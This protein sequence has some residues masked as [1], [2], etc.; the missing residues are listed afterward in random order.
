MLAANTFVDIATL[1]FSCTQAQLERAELKVSSYHVHK[2]LIMI[3]I[4][5]T[6]FALADSASIVTEYVKLVI[7]DSI[8]GFTEIAV[9]ANVFEDTSGNV[10]AE[11]L[12]Y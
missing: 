12:E 3:T 11:E 6:Y 2:S 8:G 4:V 10:V 1:L 9:R 7:A 5:S